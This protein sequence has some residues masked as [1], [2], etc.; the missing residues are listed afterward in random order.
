MRVAMPTQNNQNDTTVPR[1]AEGSLQQ[2]RRV[3]QRLDENVLGYEP[4]RD[5][6]RFQNAVRIAAQHIDQEAMSTSANNLNE[7][8]SFA[9]RVSRE[10]PRSVAF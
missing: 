2:Q 5:E 10:S 4:S 7:S 9:D 3:R 1:L 8:E 6:S